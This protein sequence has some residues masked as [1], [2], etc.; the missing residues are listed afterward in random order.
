MVVVVVVPR[1]HMVFWPL[2]IGDIDLRRQ[3]LAG[4]GLLDFDMIR[5]SGS[6]AVLL[7]DGAGQGQ[8]RQHL[9]WRQQTFLP[10]VG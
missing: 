3:D 4:S 1:T 10:R 8:H 2:R 9:R 7:E 6:I 5:M